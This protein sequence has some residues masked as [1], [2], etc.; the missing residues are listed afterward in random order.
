MKRNKAMLGSLKD[1][2]VMVRPNAWFATFFSLSI[3]A[4]LAVYPLKPSIG[5]IESLVLLGVSFACLIAGGLYALN[6]VFDAE[7]DRKNPLK[8]VRPIAS[9]KISARTG[10]SFS[11]ALV[12]SGL[13][14]ALMISLFHF[15]LGLLLVLL[16]L[17][18]SVPPLRLKETRLDLLFSGPINHIIRIIAAWALFR[19]LSQLPLVILTGLFF[20]YCTTYAYYK[21]ID[22]K[23]I[24]EK[25]FIKR[26]NII[27]VL[28]LF[29]GTGLLL[30]ITAVFIGEVPHLF[31][32]IPVALLIV[33]AVQLAI[34]ETKKIPFFH[35]LTYVYGPAGL[36]FG[37]AA[38]WA[39]AIAF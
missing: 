9:G 16:Q 25:S 11:L 35:I 14:L 8:R 26:K 28:N 15:F 37:T 20:L 10:I 29:S 27:P 4:I 38:L 33:W 32:S 21:L 2:A 1:Y 12:G 17:I 13:I 34:P 23:F 19:P 30:I 36:A 31:L 5:E 7:I 39:L 22:K 6:D 24:P 3:G 18:Y